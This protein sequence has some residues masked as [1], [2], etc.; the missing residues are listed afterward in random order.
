VLACSFV[1]MQQ[2]LIIA[3]VEVHCVAPA[4]LEAYD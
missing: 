3:D 1:V 4:F 2:H